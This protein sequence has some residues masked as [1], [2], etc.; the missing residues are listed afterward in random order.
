MAY[1]YVI[2]IHILKL[3][4]GVCL[5]KRVRS[6][7]LAHPSTRLNQTQQNEITFPTKGD[8]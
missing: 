6:L 3:H 1:G 4:L 7:T 2:A 8:G 5:G